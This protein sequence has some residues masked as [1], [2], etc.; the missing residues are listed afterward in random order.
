V[1]M[2]NVRTASYFAAVAEGLL[3]SKRHSSA[4]WVDWLGS[5]VPDFGLGRIVDL[6]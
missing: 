2:R 3:V 6:E 5:N 4:V 1:S